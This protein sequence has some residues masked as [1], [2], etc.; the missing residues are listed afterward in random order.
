MA[1]SWWLGYCDWYRVIDVGGLEAVNGDV[2]FSAAD[3]D[4]EVFVGPFETLVGTNVW[5]LEGGF[6]EFPSHEHELTLFKLFGTL[7]LIRL[8][9]LAGT[10]LRSLTR[11]RS[12]RRCSLTGAC[13]ASWMKSPG[14]A[15]G[16]PYTNSAGDALRSSFGVVRKPRRTQGSSSTQLGPVNLVLSEALRVRWSL[17]IMPLAWGW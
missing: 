16:E 5:G 6:L 8:W 13:G 15:S 14:T 17:S 1:P 10:G 11:S 7:S 2:V 4:R 9:A 12:W 3:L